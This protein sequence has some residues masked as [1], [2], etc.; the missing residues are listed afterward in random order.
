LNDLFCNSLFSNIIECDYFDVSSLD[1]T[2]IG[3]TVDHHTTL[4]LLHINTR[5]INNLKNF[6]ALHEFLTSI[7]Y[8]PDII[9]ISETRIKK[10]GVSN[11]YLVT[12]L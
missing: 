2:D 8:P 3:Q 4:T 11:K 12:K 7:S 6:D 5:S 9:Y 10:E 1:F